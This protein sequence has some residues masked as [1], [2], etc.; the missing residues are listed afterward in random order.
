MLKSIVKEKQIDVGMLFN[1]H[2]KSGDGLIDFK[3]FIVHLIIN[4][5]VSNFKSR[6]K[7]NLR[8]S[9]IYF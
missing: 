1:L 5:L 3:E 8:G 9:S 4:I 7:S 6:I 2:D